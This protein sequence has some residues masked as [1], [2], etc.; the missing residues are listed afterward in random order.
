VAG[1][2]LGGPTICSGLCRR[3]NGI[4]CGSAEKN[5]SHLVPPARNPAGDLPPHDPTERRESN[6]KAPRRRDA[7]NFLVCASA[8]SRLCVKISLGIPGRTSG[9]LEGRSSWG[10]RCRRLRGDGRSF[11]PTDVGRLAQERVK[12]HLGDLSPRALQEERDSGRAIGDTQWIGREATII[13][14]QIQRIVAAPDLILDVA[15][16]RVVDLPEI[17]VAPER[18]EQLGGGALPRLSGCCR[19]C[20][21]RR[22]R[23]TGR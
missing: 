12:E 5:T 17:V 19:I 20:P 22:E 1:V 4:S 13:C 7:E 21:E 6:A 16:D 15:P 23:S 8:S 9:V 18:R 10:R 2:F 14:R 11:G 3:A